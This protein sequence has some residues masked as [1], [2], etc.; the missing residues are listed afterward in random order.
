MV[1]I[2]FPD[3]GSVSQMLDLYKE[4]LEGGV[5]PPDPARIVEALL[6]VPV[7]VEHLLPIPPVLE[8]VHSEFTEKLTESLPRFP[9]T[10]DCPVVE[11]KKWIKE[12]FRL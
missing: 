5:L 6:R 9:M 4:K 1:E 12:D 2:K 3:K 10:S 8:K 11:W 7:G